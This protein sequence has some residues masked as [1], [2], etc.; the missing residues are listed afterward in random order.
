[1]NTTARSQRVYDHRLKAL[2]QDT[3][4]IRLA[5]DTEVPR[6]TARGWLRQP[7]QE[8]ITLDIFKNQERGLLCEVMALRRRNRTLLAVLRLVLVLLRVS[9]FTL[10]HSRL[11]DGDEKAALLRAI[12]RARCALPLRAVLRI[13]KLSSTRYYAWRRAEDACGLADASSCP[14]TSPHRLTAQ[15]IQAIQEMVTSTEYRHVLTGTLAIFA[16]RLGKVFASPATWY[17]L[18]RKHRW[19]RPR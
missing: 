3:G 12:E 4:D 17:R 9:G 10:A 1:M 13:L 18:I 14:H 7:R 11:G 16:Q 19:R 15:E 6:S 8:V 2:I 5:T